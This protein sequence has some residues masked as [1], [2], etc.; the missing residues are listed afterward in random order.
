MMPRLLIGALASL[1]LATTAFAQVTPPATQWRPAREGQPAPAHRAANPPV[2]LHHPPISENSPRPTRTIAAPPIDT[3]TRGAVHLEDGP[4][5]LPADLVEIP[6]VGEPSRIANPQADPA[7]GTSTGPAP[8]VE[9]A[10]P[11]DATADFGSAPM[12]GVPFTGNDDDYWFNMESFARTAPVAPNMLGD[13][14]GKFYIGAPPAPSKNIIRTPADQAYY[15]TLI[16]WKAADNRSPR[17]QTRAWVSENYFNRAFGSQVN[18]NR[19]SFGGE[20]A[21]FQQLFSLE[22]L[23]DNNQFMNA[24]FTDT[25]IWGDLNLTLKGVLLQRTQVLLAWGTAVGFP[26]GPRPPGTPGASVQVSPFVGY[27][28]T[29]ASGRWFVQGFEQID[30]ML[31]ENRMLLHTDIGTGYWLMPLDDNRR[32]VT[33]LAPTVELHVYSPIKRVNTDPPQLEG[34]VFKDVVNVTLG[35]TTFFTRYLSVAAGVGLPLSDSTDY[36]FEFMAHVNWL[37]RGLR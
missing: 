3:A 11:N 30:V 8:A 21:M 37:F 9:P 23:A 1:A 7:P 19:V 14:L 22:L 5:P 36:D 28:F 31:R 35:A 2:R 32:G 4:T 34:L 16:R 26:T 20:L 29:D 12:D 24:P 13:F 27:I 18:L 6:P 33:G 17:P 10:G 15:K 25:N